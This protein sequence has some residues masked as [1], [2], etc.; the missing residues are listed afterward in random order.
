MPV[1][2]KPELIDLPARIDGEKCVLRPYRPG[3]GVAIFHAVDRSRA[4]L[5]LW[6]DWADE[7][8]AKGWGTSGAA[9]QAAR[10]RARR[11]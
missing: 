9:A 11:V 2:D 5:K 6:V 10:S 1:I 7:G 4:D 8:T 3:D